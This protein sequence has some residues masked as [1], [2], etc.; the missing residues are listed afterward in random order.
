MTDPIAPVLMLGGMTR[1]LLANTIGEHWEICVQDE[2]LLELSLVDLSEVVLID[3]LSPG[4]ERIHGDD[5]LDRLHKMHIL[6][7]GWSAF[8][9]LRFNYIVKGP[10]SELEWLRTHRGVEQCAF[11]GTIF[12]CAHDRRIEGVICL[13]WNRRRKRWGFYVDR[14]NAIAHSRHAKCLALPAS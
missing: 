13:Y 14:F 6:P 2:R 7:L 8:L 12:Q 11:F 5:V 4:E 1:I 9:K 3:C 10:E